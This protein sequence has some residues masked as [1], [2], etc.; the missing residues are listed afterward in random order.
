[1]PT[2]AN[3]PGSTDKPLGTTGSGSLTSLPPLRTSRADMVLAITSRH[4]RSPF[5]NPI[6]RQPITKLSEQRAKGT[7]GRERHATSSCPLS[8]RLTDLRIAEKPV[9][10]GADGGL[11]LWRGKEGWWSCSASSVGGMHEKTTKYAAR[12]SMYGSMKARPRIER[13]NEHV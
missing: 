8:T 9:R 13:M 10:M 2:H 12:Q 1:M 3:R 5:A 4:L 7:K 11:E 6:H